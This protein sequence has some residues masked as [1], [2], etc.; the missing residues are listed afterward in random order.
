MGPL[1]IPR[2]IRGGLRVHLAGWRGG[3]DRGAMAEDDQPDQPGARRAKAA[4]R[5]WV[6]RPGFEE[7]YCAY[8]ADQ[9]AQVPAGAVLLLSHAKREGIDQTRSGR[10]IALLRAF[11][12]YDLPL[13]LPE[14]VPHDSQGL[15]KG[16]HYRKEYEAMHRAM[17]QSLP[18]LMGHVEAGRAVAVGQA[19]QVWLQP[20]FQDEM[21]S[22]LLA[23]A[24][25]YSL[26]NMEDRC[27]VF[28][29][30]VAPRCV[31][32]GAAFPDFLTFAAQVAAQVA[33]TVTEV[34]AKR[35]PKERAAIAL[36]HRTT[37][38]LL[39][40]EA[41][42]SASMRM[43][44]TW[45]AKPDEELQAIFAK[46]IATRRARRSTL[47]EAQRAAKRAAR[48]AAWAAKT[49][50]ELA[51]IKAQART[52]RAA[53]S[54]DR[55]LQW[56]ERMRQSRAATR[57]RWLQRLRE[58]IA[59]RL[60]SPERRAEWIAK[61]KA[62]ILK[63]TPEQRDARRA[64]MVQ[65]Y[66][67]QPGW[68]PEWSKRV[69]ATHARKSAEAR[70]AENAKHAA[71]C[72]AWTP[73]FRALRREHIIAGIAARSSAQ[74]AAIVAKFRETLAS[75]PP[76]AVE[77]VAANLRAAAAR[78]PTA[79]RERKSQ[80]IKLA[81]AAIT[82]EKHAE[83]KAANAQ[84]ILAKKTAEGRVLL[85]RFHAGTL[86]PKERF[87]VSKNG[88]CRAKERLTNPGVLQSES[89]EEVFQLV[90]AYYSRHGS[91]RQQDSKWKPPAA[92][93]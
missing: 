53:W 4:R 39:S 66:F 24:P 30:A 27:R 17:A 64:L 31:G 68:R 7:Q 32:H 1:R 63:R 23:M 48:A 37:V 57:E 9:L 42:A 80:L 86:T 70:A 12:V 83:I 79:A 81:H 89:L 73:E 14:D 21:E 18:L 28:Y 93:A 49:P 46:A 35:G 20:L 36:K 19:S 55:K 67:S 38:A 51:G 71:T 43:R 88:R 45:A 65:R 16:S 2:L 50:E 60:A 77:R 72:A 33:A 25:Y 29:D 26:L 91:Q 61:L 6:A 82:E 74:R 54:A 56:R 44:E 76:E 87:A 22:G 75:R 13:W 5:T 85:E 3:G 90:E 8:Y 10:I 11:G 92:V 15:F 84:A 52:T 59:R 58:A 69:M 41:K 47:T 34:W 62:G 78:M 40:P